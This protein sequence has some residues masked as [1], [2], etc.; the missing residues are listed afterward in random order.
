[1]RSNK[2]LGVDLLDT[3]CIFAIERVRSYGIAVWCL[4]NFRHDVDLKATRDVSL[5]LMPFGS[6]HGGREIE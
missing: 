2:S 6:K 5:L 4:M 1:M 3:P